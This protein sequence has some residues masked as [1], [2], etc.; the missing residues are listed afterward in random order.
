MM[1][2][3]RR[4]ATGAPPFPPSAATNAASISG[5]SMPRGLALQRAI[6]ASS[7]AAPNARPHPTRQ[8]TTPASA[9]GGGSPPSCSSAP[10]TANAPGSLR[11]FQVVAIQPS[12][13][14]A[15]VMRNSS[16]WPLKG[17]RCRSRV[18]RCRRGAELPRVLLQEVPD[19]RRSGRPLAKAWL[20]RDRASFCAAPSLPQLLTLP[21]AWTHS[22]PLCGSQRSQ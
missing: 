4:A 10:A 9:R 13:R 2:T 20:K 6:M 19:P 11:L 1:T 22:S 16:I 12:E 17:W 5:Q 7:Q 21:L 3:G 8:T 18:V 14:W 15:C